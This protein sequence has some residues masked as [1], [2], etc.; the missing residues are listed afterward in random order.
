M[1]TEKIIRNTVYLCVMNQCLTS[2][3]FTKLNTFNLAH[4]DITLSD[5]CALL[6]KHDFICLQTKQKLQSPLH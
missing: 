6:V 4:T 2:I 5:C 1:L 3:T